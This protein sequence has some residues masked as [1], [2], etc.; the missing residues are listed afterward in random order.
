MDSANKVGN[1]IHQRTEWLSDLWKPYTYIRGDVNGDGSFDIADVVL[2][3]KWI[4]AVP[5]THL[6]QWQAVDLCKDE[7]LDVFDLCLLKNELINQT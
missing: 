2:F 6:S 1:Y 7:R 5:N 3:Q 4:I